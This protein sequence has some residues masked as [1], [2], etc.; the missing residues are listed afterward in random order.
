MGGGKIT[1]LLVS[2]AHVKTGGREGRA[3][4][5]DQSGRAP[6]FLASLPMNLFVL[7]SFYRSLSLWY[8]TNL[9][10]FSFM[11][12]CP[13]IATALIITIREGVDRNRQGRSE[14]T[15]CYIICALC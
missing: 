12:R 6:R 3:F 8:H 9:K 10:K 5:G 11:L 13:R 2:P 7:K 4:F 15:L 14:V 1:S